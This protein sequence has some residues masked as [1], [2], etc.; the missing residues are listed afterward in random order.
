[1]TAEDLASEA[2]TRALAKGVVFESAEHLFNW[3]LVVAR[4]LH[5]DDCRAA[6]RRPDLCELGDHDVAT[7]DTATVVEQRMQLRR[8]LD[9]L[10]EMSPD[11]RFAVLTEI[12]PTDR[13]DAV[14]LNVRRHRARARLRA[15]LAAVTGLLGLRRLPKVALATTPVAFATALVTVLLPAISPP[16]GGGG[17]PR[18]APGQAQPAEAA[19]GA[20]LQRVSARSVVPAVRPSAVPA[21]R[22]PTARRP[23]ALTAEPPARREIVKVQHGPALVEAHE[24]RDQSSEYLVCV[25]N[26]RIGTVCAGRVPDL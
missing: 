9:V 3:T 23:P 14:R 21:P 22:V 19:T 5:V 1:M 24:E 4:N 11:D 8:A 26:S 17:V 16:G 20:R 10:A 2:V 13:R 15:A 6:Q 12:T 18:P 25:D 7:P